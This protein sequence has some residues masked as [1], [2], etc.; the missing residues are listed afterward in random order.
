MRSLDVGCCHNVA[1]PRRITATPTAL[2][3][4][5]V[6]PGLLVPLDILLSQ[7]LMAQAGQQGAGLQTVDNHLHFVAL[8]FPD[9]ESEVAPANLP[10]LPHDSINTRAG[11]T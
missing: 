8:V 2:H 10:K 7:E 5:T 1:Q 9:S 11:E 4:G 3:G 6:H